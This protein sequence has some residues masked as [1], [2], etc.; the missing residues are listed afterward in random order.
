MRERVGELEAAFAELHPYAVP[1][2]LAL[3]VAAG[4]ARY[5]GWVAAAVGDVDA[6]APTSSPSP[7]ASDVPHTSQ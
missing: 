7:G 2:L 5:V 4:I 6:P 1:E 3:P